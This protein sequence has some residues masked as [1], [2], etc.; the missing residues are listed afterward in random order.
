MKRAFATGEL[1]VK[2]SAF[3]T[4]AFHAKYV[5]FLVFFVVISTAFA[6]TS[7]AFAEDS[8]NDGNDGGSAVAPSLVVGNVNAADGEYQGGTIPILRLTFLDGVDSETG[9]PITG[10]EKI[11]KMNE[12]PNHEYKATGV[13]FELVVPGTYDNPEAGIKDGVSGYKGASGS[14]EFIRG[15]GNST[16]RPDIEKK[17]YKFKL[18]KK[19]NLFGFGE[20]KHWVLLANHFDDSL[21]I[22]RLV[23]WIG[24]EMGMAYT[25]RG[26]PVDL[27]MNGE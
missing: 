10:A 22:D 4:L 9:E 3:P 8:S 19:D 20:N 11:K 7:S 13:N 17:P 6:T 21:I 23:G 15:R 12:S 25:P 2:G 27:F 26:V 1:R 5:A 18:N 24:N 14:I 16:W